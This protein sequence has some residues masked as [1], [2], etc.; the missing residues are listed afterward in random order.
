[1]G[2][3]Q[4]PDPLMMTAV[5]MVN[6]QRLN[7]YGYAVNNPF[8]YV[9]PTGEDAIAVNFLREVPVGG[10]EGIVNVHSDGSASYARFGPRNGRVPHP[11]RSC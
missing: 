10:H 8:Q 7:L 3:F 2:R 4:T 11:S 9:D 6:P 5:C 1:M